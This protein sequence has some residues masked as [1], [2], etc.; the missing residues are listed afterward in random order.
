MWRTTYRSRKCA[1]WERMGS[2]AAGHVLLLGLEL[3]LARSHRICMSMGGVRRG[4]CR[5]K[6]LALLLD[7]RHKLGHSP[8]FLCHSLV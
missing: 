5:G 3:S 2:G 7:L 6:L 1:G 4:F 8:L